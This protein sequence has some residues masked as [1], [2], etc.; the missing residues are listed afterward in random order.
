MLFQM[1]GPLTI[2]NTL[3]DVKHILKG[4]RKI[5][6]QMEEIFGMIETEMLR[7]L[8]EVKKAGVRLVSY[9]DSAGECA[10]SGAEI[11]GMDDKNVYCPVSEKRPLTFWEMIWR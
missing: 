11:H 9:A 4:I 6:D 2:W 10:D 7:L 5:P 3:I 1:S 8:V